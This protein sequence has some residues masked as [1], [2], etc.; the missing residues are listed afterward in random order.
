MILS[1][2]KKYNYI[3]ELFKTPNKLIFK[4]DE[5]FTTD[6]V[7]GKV[8]KILINLKDSK[9]T[10]DNTIVYKFSDDVDFMIDHEALVLSELSKLKIP[11]FVKYYDI[12]ND[13]DILNKSNTTNSKILLMEHLYSNYQPECLTFYNILKNNKD[14]GYKGKNIISSQIL[15]I[16]MALEIAQNE[17]SFTH[18][19]LHMDNVLELECEPN[20]VFLYELPLEDTKEYYV[21]PTFGYYPCIIDVGMSY[22]F[23]VNDKPM[24][25]SIHNYSNGSQSSIFDTFNDI[26]HLLI[27]SFYYIEDC[28]EQYD[29]MSKKLKSIFSNVPVLRKRG[30]KQLKNNLADLLNEKLK[31]EVEIFND[32]IFD[33]QHSDICGLLSALVKLPLQI[34][35]YERSEDERSSVSSEENGEFNKSFYNFLKEIKYI[36]NNVFTRYHDEL[37]LNIFKTV[38]ETINNK[39]NKLDLS[40]SANN[41]NKSDNFKSNL[42][43]NLKELIDK[44][45]VNI[46]KDKIENINFDYLYE[47]G[48]SIGIQLSHFFYE[49]VSS[50]TEVIT[51]G[52]IKINEKHELYSPIDFFHLFY[53]KLSPFFKIDEDTVVYSFENKIP[54]I[55]SCKSLSS[56]QLNQINKSSYLTKGNRLNEC[57]DGLGKLSK[58]ESKEEKN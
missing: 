17:T 37:L 11:H 28:N 18:Y 3:S 2:Y 52:Y 51:K 5:K 20:S 24:L 21:V 38:I 44:F 27:S 12:M 9:K 35:E 19:D 47:D 29:E 30:W 4:N 16:L 40:G 49:L 54:T 15:Q 34:S 14:I 48:I 7:T 43:K 36:H 6:G 56:D 42:I 58:V 1:R 57:L 45:D 25:S 23:N 33:D 55:R 13:I 32:E 26:H 39:S 22:V 31:N 41:A 53:E 50:N 10:K 46:D 8:G